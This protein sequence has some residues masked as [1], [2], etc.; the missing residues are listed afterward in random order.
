MSRPPDLRGRVRAGT[1][2]DFDTIMQIRLSVREN[3]LADPRAVTR[4]D[5][6][7]RFDPAR[8]ACWVFDD[9]GQ[10]AG[11]AW[12]DFKLRNVWA[13][14]VRPACERRGVGRLLHETMMNAFFARDATA[15]WLGTGPGTRAAAFYRRAGWQEAGRM[16]NGDLRFEMTAAQWQQRRPRD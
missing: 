14:F 11:F 9:D 1:L 4:A 16:S 3:V 13:L 5:Y 2:A 10:L 12:A 6:L 15:V 8:G 7:E